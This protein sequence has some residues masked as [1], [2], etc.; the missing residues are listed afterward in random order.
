MILSPECLDFCTIYTFDI[1]LKIRIILYSIVNFVIIS[2]RNV[3]NGK[4]SSKVKAKQNILLL[5]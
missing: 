5:Q 4:E 3:F 2:W 1:V